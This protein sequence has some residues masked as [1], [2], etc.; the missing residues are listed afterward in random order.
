MKSAFAVLLLIA[1]AAGLGIEIGVGHGLGF[2]LSYDYDSY[3]PPTCGA[4]CSAK[5]FDM[6]HT[7]GTSA[8]A[9]CCE[10]CT[11][12]VSCDCTSIDLFVNQ[13]T[14]SRVATCTDAWLDIQR[15][16]CVCELNCLKPVGNCEVFWISRLVAGASVIVSAI[17]L[18]ILGRATR[19]GWIKQPMLWVCVLLV[20]G[21]IKFGIGVACL[22]I[23]FV[24]QNGCEFDTLYYLVP[25]L[26]IAG[27]ASWI[28]R[29]LVLA[30]RRPAPLLAG[31]GMQGAHEV[32]VGVAST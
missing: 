32:Q 8:F 5:C 15:E 18:G 11:W 12:S 23:I 6:G 22:V 21:G 7:N 26:A 25:G 28:L 9:L 24:N 19:A 31:Q 27:G 30:K 3:V 10:L 4:T 1:P 16:G 20:I 14:T 13:L 29:A 2:G 17:G